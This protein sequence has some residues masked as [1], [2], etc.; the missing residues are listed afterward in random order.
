MLLHLTERRSLQDRFV[1]G[2]AESEFSDVDT[3]EKIHSDFRTL[4]YTP[5]S[6]RTLCL[7]ENELTSLKLPIIRIWDI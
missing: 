1:R 2:G 4:Q 6:Q 7:S 3:L 5:D